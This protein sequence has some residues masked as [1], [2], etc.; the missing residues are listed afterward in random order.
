MEGADDEADCFHVQGAARQFP[1]SVQEANQ[2]PINAGEAV[3][4]ELTL[5]IKLVN[6]KTSSQPW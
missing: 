3:T 4:V 1:L 6:V 5:S 2:K